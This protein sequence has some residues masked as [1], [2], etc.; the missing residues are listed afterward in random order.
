M[1]RV[2]RADLQR[3]LDALGRWDDGEISERLDGYR[4]ALFDVIGALLNELE[5]D[6]DDDE[7]AR[8]L[9]RGAVREAAVLGLVRGPRL[10]SEIAKD[11]GKSPESVSRALADLAEAEVVQTLAMAQADK[12]QRPY[13]LTIKG[14]ELGRRLMDQRDL[15]EGVSDGLELASEFYAA[16]MAQGRISYP[17]F[18]RW[19]TGRVGR[20]AA[21]AACEK[22]VQHGAA[23][24]VVRE[25]EGGI[26]VAMRDVSDEAL[27]TSEDGDEHVT[28]WFA[29]W[30]VALGERHIDVLYVRTD[31]HPFCWQKV[32]NEVNKGKTGVNVRLCSTADVKLAGDLNELYRPSL[33]KERYA[34]MYTHGYTWLRE[35]DQPNPI[36]EGAS[37]RHMLVPAEDE[38]P[39]ATDWPSRGLDPVFVREQVTSLRA[40]QR[41]ASTT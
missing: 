16:L 34:I 25:M 36:V 28:D 14:R 4:D 3:V 40:R 7:L 18:E 22:L 30:V 23:R 31:A 17:D 9:R 8:W 2:G 20:A 19:A 41:C 10:P 11:A 39:P 24:D 38:G 12:R 15:P 21:R 29:A 1:A 5:R 26:A 37:E 13:R 35:H 32:I 27:K 33:E 6:E